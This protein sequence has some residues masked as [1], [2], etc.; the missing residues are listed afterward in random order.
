MSDEALVAGFEDCSLPGSAFHHREHVRL[1][2]IY[3]R[4][5]GETA[6][7]ARLED[8]L[9]RY[10]AHNGAAGKFHYTITRAWLRLVASAAGQQPSACFDELVARRPELLDKST[11]GRHYSGGVLG[12]DRA[13]LGFV[14]PDLEPLPEC[15]P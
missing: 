6:A 13:R 9:K 8:G 2:W 1:T 7:L 5:Y 14:E 11:L 10:A 4:R 15:R 12:T 3:V